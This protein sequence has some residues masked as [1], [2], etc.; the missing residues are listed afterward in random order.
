MR[1]SNLCAAAAAILMTASVAT[2][3]TPAAPATA[4]ALRQAPMNYRFAV[5]DAKVTALSDCT[6]AMDLHRVL[7]GITP[8]ETDA[9]LAANYLT[10]P[11]EVSLN[12]FLIEAAGR[13]VL[14]DA[15]GGDILGPGNCGRSLDGLTAAGVRPEQVTDILI[16]HLHLDHSGGLVR[17][18]KA[19]FPNAT[20]HVAKAELD[21][22]LKPPAPPEGR[23]AAAAQLVL[24]LLKPYLDAGKV[25]T[26]EAATGEI[27][28]GVSAQVIP[29]HTPGSA[30]F[31]LKSGGQTLVFMGDYNPMLV[32]GLR[33]PEVTF[34]TDADLPR[35]RAAREH[36]LADF[37]RSGVL[38]AA[39][40]LA[41]P[42]VGHVGAD[43]R[44]YR[45]FPVTFKDRDPNQPPAKF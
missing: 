29:G 1:R 38:V 7:G 2:A 6:I 37:A 4:G 5:G 8:A 11:A 41:F 17:N 18:G 44:G 22:Y 36:L 12:V 42:G 25:Q 3:E 40:H 20:L 10:N 32:I 35:T 33:R 14:V 23:A 45:W 24:S 31:T 30:V 9:I 21:A 39:P 19:T 16:T 34:I 28:P 43:G 26:F 13:V 15:G 27:L